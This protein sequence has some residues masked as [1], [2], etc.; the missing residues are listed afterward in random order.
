[1]FE[2]VETACFLPRYLHSLKALLSKGGERSSFH[3]QERS[4][5]F[6]ALPWRNKANVLTAY[7][8]SAWNFNA[9]SLP[10][11]KEGFLGERGV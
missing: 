4:R 8:E 6:H 9:V 7:I 1:M 10:C 3:A 5:S 2:S 11:Q